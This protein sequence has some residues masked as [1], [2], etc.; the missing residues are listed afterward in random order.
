MKVYERIHASEKPYSCNFCDKKFAQIN[1]LNVHERI[2]TGE[3]PYSC[4]ICDKKFTDS[5]NLKQHEKE[6][7]QENLHII[8]KVS[9][10]LSFLG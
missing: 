8:A 7:E 4:K 2:H 6:E 3:K 5:S 9:Q 1:S 10:L